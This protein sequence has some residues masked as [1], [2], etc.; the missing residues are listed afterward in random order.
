MA[1]SSHQEELQLALFRN[2]NKRN[3]FADRV[4]SETFFL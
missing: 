2:K 1:L 3:L 4:C